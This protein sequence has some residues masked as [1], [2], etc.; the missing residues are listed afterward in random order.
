VGIHPAGG[1]PGAALRPAGG[2][3]VGRGLRRDRWLGYA[4]V[5]PMLLFLLGIIFFPLAHAF[6]TSL[7]REAGV[8]IRFVG[9]R[10][11]TRLLEDEAFW[12]SLRVSG[13]FTAAAVALHVLLAMP[14]ALFLNQLR[15]GR[16]GPRPLLA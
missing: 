9:R 14:V 7:Y 12:N 11:D 10:N 3:W 1:R 15:R 13:V 2:R 16:S 8:T 6:L 4:F 5:A